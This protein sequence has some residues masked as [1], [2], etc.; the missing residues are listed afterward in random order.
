MWEFV[1]FLFK[2][3]KITIAPVISIGVSPMDKIQQVIDKFLPEMYLIAADSWT[4]RA[5]EGETMEELSKKW[6]GRM[7]E[8]PNRIERL[9]CIGKTK[10]GKETFTRLYDIVRNKD[11]K[12]TDFVQY[13]GDNPKL[14]STK[15]T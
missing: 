15:L 6:G 1:I 9:T 4:A 12:I 11:G 10:N 7:S 2:D 14:E 5:A 8:H 13:R 3:K